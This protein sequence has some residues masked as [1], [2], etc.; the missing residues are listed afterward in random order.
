MRAFE[1]IRVLDLTHVFAGPFCTFQLAVMGAEVIKIESPDLPDM[2]RDEGNIDELNELGLSNFYACQ[3]SEKKSLSLNLKMND[4]KRFFLKLLKTADVLVQNYS[5]NSIDNLG[6]SYKKLKKINPRLIYCS[7]TGFGRTG[8]KSEHPAYD[9]VIQAFS[10]L[11]ELNGLKSTGPLRVG[12][13]VVD[14]G[15]GIHAAFAISSALYRR[16][17]TGKGLEIDVSMLD[18]ALM[19]MT[20]TVSETIATGVSKPNYGNDHPDNAG[21]GAFKASD[22]DLVIGAFTKKQMQNLFRAINLED[23][24]NEIAVMSK[25]ELKKN[26]KK[27]KKKI[28][29]VIITNTADYWEEVLNRHHVPSSKVRTL[30]EALSSEQIKSRAILQ[31]SLLHKN[32]LHPK[33]LPTTAFCYSDGSPRITKSAKKIGENNK[34]I[35]KN[36]LNS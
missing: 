27:L 16:E 31:N 34:E 9:S 20:S 1:G 36:I 3:N 17:I 12:P 10:G 7:M 13:A 5:G 2:M 21:Y 11:M 6:L 22:R 29:K 33:K 30:S 8:P 26:K 25:K 35:R 19:L 14:Y 32:S 15:T 28:E 4:D 23:I 24:S 18:A